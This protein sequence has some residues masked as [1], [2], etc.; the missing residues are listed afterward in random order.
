MENANRKMIPM[1]PMQDMVVFPGM[2]VHIEARR[3]SSCDA[4]ESVMGAD[5]KIV[6]ALVDPDAGGIEKGAF[7]HSVGTMVRVKQ[8]V[9]LP[10]GGVRAAVEG[11]Y[12]VML[13]IPEKDGFFRVQSQRI[14]SRGF[15]PAQEEWEGMRRVVRE[16]LGEYGKLNHT[17]PESVFREILE[18]TNPGALAD[19]IASMLLT[20][21]P[22]KQQIILEETD[23]RERIYAAME[24]LQQ[25]VEIVRMEQKMM[26]QVKKQMDDNQR[27]FFMREQM[28]AIQ[29]ELGEEDDEYEDESSEY[30]KKIGEAGFP[31][32]VR[33]KVEKELERLD[34]TPPMSQESAVIRTWLDTIFELPWTT[35]SEDEED[36]GRSAEILKSEHFGL[37]EV[38]D[39]IIEHLAVMKLTKNN[40]GTILCLAGPPGVGKT[41][42][43][44]SVAKAMNKK[45]V[46]M[47]L[48]GV[49]DEAE[50]RGHRKTYVGS[51]PGRIINA[52]RTAGTKNPLILLDEIDK[53]G[54]DYK[55]D[56]AAALLEV[57]DSEQNKEFRDHYLEVPFDLSHVFF[58]T[59]ANDLSTIPAPLLDRMEIVELSGYIEEEKLSIAKKFLIPKQSEKN[60]LPKG[61]LSITDGA[62]REMIRLYTAEA[63]VRQ[64]EREVAKIARRLAKEH[65]IEKKEYT[66]INKRNLEAYLG[67]PKYSYEKIG[68]TDEIGVVNGLAWTAAGGD[69]MPIEVNVFEGTGK[70]ELTG[71]LGDVMK[72]SA[73]AAIS[74]LRAN[75]EALGISPTFYKDKDI[76]VHV[77][78]GAVPKDGPSAGITMALAVMSSLIGKPVRRDI[79]MTGEINLRGKVMPIGGL[80]EKTMAA[81]RSGVKTVLFPKDNE[82]DLVKI[83]ETVRTGLTLI[84]VSTMAEVIEHA[85]L[86]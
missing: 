9:S 41:S 82:K 72:E 21:Q 5:R 8:L 81:Y 42:V 44:R 74:Y 36:V 15:R 86:R 20:R 13:G 14:P 59:T 63:G 80:R 37:E 4:L 84:P 25:E 31:E 43:A 83:P 30:R 49:R 11:L 51:M 66:P 39:R 40:A 6:L 16:L 47:S 52:I 69:T 27:E 62:L 29:R 57:L 71:H 55:G 64:L 46:R 38:K 75:A 7:V 12:R 3:V 50:I 67:V 24:M 1:I 35:E 73:K 54:A 33:A 68:K 45:Y 53:L 23:S 18:T 76:H 2:S 32:D 17:V 60:G 85:L 48:G 61:A 19:K 79:A 56:P 22:E 65:L 10:D 78:E 28:K 77:P 34:K 26:A 70:I 58:I